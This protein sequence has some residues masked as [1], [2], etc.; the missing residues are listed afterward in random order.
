LR[1]STVVPCTVRFLYDD[2]TLLCTVTAPLS[3]V[4]CAAAFMPYASPLDTEE[5]HYA[6]IET[7]QQAADYVIANQFTDPEEDTLGKQ[8]PSTNP[9]Y[10]TVISP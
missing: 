3:H 8:Q 5:P 6:T 1:V 4:V 2:D 9:T 7:M 10:L